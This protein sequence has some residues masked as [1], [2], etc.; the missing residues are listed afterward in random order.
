MGLWFWRWNLHHQGVPHNFVEFVVVKACFL[1]KSKVKNLKIPQSFFRK[2][3]TEN[4][5]VDT[6][7]A[8]EQAS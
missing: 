4:F 2:A 1:S 6:R 8:G 7:R 5:L 3:Y